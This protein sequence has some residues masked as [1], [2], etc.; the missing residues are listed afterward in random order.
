MVDRSILEF[1]SEDPIDK[2]VQEDIVTYT[3]A[4]G[5]PVNFGVPPNVLESIPNTY[6]QKALIRASWAI[7]GK[8][9]ISHLAQRQYYSSVMH[10]P[11]MKAA[12]SCGVDASNVY[13]WL[14]NN[15]TSDLTFTIN[16]A[17]YTI[18]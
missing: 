8:N 11:V 3:V 10:Q 6:G 16:Y 12:V 5:T 2:V 14:I 17:V 18:S 7:D 9:F 13:F 1:F 4:A 15:F